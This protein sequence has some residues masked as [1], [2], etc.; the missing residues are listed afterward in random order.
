[1]HNISKLLGHNESGAK[2]KVNSTMCFQKEVLEISHNQVNSTPESSRTKRNQN[3][4][5]VW[6]QEIVKL[7]AE[8]NQ[9]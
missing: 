2:R 3:T 4:H 7:R 1:M 5:K 8:I 9:L 6:Q